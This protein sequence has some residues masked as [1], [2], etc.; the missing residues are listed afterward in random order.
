MS[1][2]APANSTV[3]IFVDGVEYARVTADAAGNWS[4]TPTADLATGAHTINA[5]DEVQGVASVR[6]NTN[7][8]TVATDTTPPD[9]TIVSGPALVTSS[10]SATFDFSANE[11]PVT[12]ECSLDGGAYAACTD[13]QTFT[14]LANGGHTLSVRARDAAG[15]VDPTPATY[16]WTVDTTAPDTTIVSGPAAVT[17]SNSATFDFSSNESPVTYQCSLD[18]AAFVACTDPVTF[19]GLADGNHT[20]AVRA[21]DAAGNVDP[22]P[23]THAWTVDTSPP[24]TVIVSGP[25]AVTSATTATFD[26]SSPDSPVT[27]ECSLDSGAY[28]ACT[29]PVTFTGLA[30]GNHTLSV[31]ARDAAGNVDPTPATYAWRV[32]TTAPDTTIVSGP[33]SVTNSTSAT[34]DFSSNESPVTYQC[35][36]DSGAFV[37]CTDPQTFTGLAQGN[38][39][40]AVRA[41]DA[42]GNVDPTP[43]TYSWTIDTTPPDTA[44]V[45]GPSAVTSSTSA[46]FDFSSPDSPVTYECSLDGA[47]YAA[48]TDPVTFTGLA[49]GNHTLSVRARDA[50]GNVDPTP[51]TH[52]WRVDT[53]VP[54]TVI[55]SG[56]SG[57]TASTSATFDFSS[58]ESPVTYECSLDGAAFAA[59]TDPVTFTGLAQGNHTLSVRAR[60]A[61]GNVDPTPATRSWTVDTV[62][63][64]TSFTSTPPLTTN[65]SV[66]NFDFNSNESP[67]TYEC[68]LDG[69]A[70]FTPCADPQ[71]FTGLANGSHTLEVRA[72]DS[73]GNVDPTPAT[74]TWTVD[75]SPPDTTIVSGPTGSTTSTSA[76]FDFS[77]NESPVTYQCS[78]D[79]AAF[80]ACTDPVTFTGL[81][82]GSH[83][84]SVRAVDAAGNV[85]PTPATRT[86][87]VDRTAPDTTIVSGPATVT[88]ATTATFDFTSNESPVT[89]ECSLDG[90]AFTACTDPV[91]F[92]GLADGGH[93][94]SVRARDA[95]GNVDP[96]P[97]TYA[98]TVDRTAPDTTIVSGPPALTSSTS[99]TFD[100]SSNESPV[101]YQCSLD[102][103]AFAACTD[104][105][106]FS[107]LA[108]G[109]HT[110][111]VR[112]VD[113]AGNVDPTPATHAWTVDRTAPD[114][115]IVSGPALVTNATTATFDFS[116]N[117]SPVTYQCSLDGGAF[118]ACTDPVTFT[119]LAE[120][121]HTLAVR[122]VD[123]A[124]NVDPTPATYSWTV[125][126]TAPTRPVVTAPADGSVVPTQQP[127]FTGTADPGTLVTVIV[128]GVTLG[129]VTANAS[130]NWSFP[131]PVALAQGPHSVVATSTDAAGNVSQPSNTNAFI[132]DTVRP[133]AP[134]IERPADGATVATRRPTY[135]G[136][137]E[138]NAQVTVTVDGRVVGT[139]TAD[140]DGHWS[141]VETTD[142]TDGSHTVDATATDAAGNISEATSHDFLVDTS[143]PDTLIVSGP[144]S[145]TNATSATFDFDQVNGGVRYECSL[146]GAAFTACTDPVTF[147]GLAEGNHTLAVRAVNALGTADASP[148][149]HAWT[150][151]L[152]APTLPT[153]DSPSNGATV[154][155]ATPTITGT[156]EPG[157]SIY[158]DLDGATYGPIPVN[159]Q[160][161]W[162]FTV[163]VP[164]AEGP[165]TV[166]ATSVDAAG[167]TAG[168]VTSTFIVDLLGPDTLIVSGPP[169]LTNTTS[170]TFD[171]DQTGGGVSYQCSLD[172]ASYVPCTD[173]VTFSGLADGEHVL[174]VRAVDAV[175]NVD[176]SPAEHRWTVDTTAPDTLIDS[177]PAL[178]TNATTATFDFEAS[179]PGSTFECSIDGATF[180][181]CTDPDTFAGFAE[182]EHTLEVRAVDAAGNVDP[183][184]ATYT[185]TVDLTA[186]VV[187]TIVTPPNGAV[188]DSG[189]VTITGTADGATSVTLTLGGTT[190]GPIPVDSSGNWTFT[191]PV[192]LADGPYT[193]SVV[194]VDN[195]GNT[196]GPATSTFTVDTSAPDTFIDSGPAALT[197]ETTANF[198]FSSNES[199]VTY[200]CSLDGAAFTAC[201]A[202]ASF[203]SLADGDH[204]LAVRATDAAGNVDASPATHT[205][206]VDTQAPVVT[207][208]TPA[209]GAVLTNPQVTYSGTTE[210]GASVTVVVDGVN[211]GTVTADSSGNWTL[212][213]GTELGEGPHSV[214]VTATDPAGNTSQPV[215]HPF[216][217]DALPPDTTFT[218]TPP[219]L[220]NS[221][222][223]TFEF[224]SDESPVTYECSLDGAAFTACTTPLTLSGL[225]EG[226]HTLSVRARDTDGNVDPTPA[227]YTWTVDTT[228]PDTSIVSGPVLVDAPTT[229][230]FDFDTVGGVSYQCSLDGAAFAACTDPNTFTGLTSGNHTLAVRAVDAA[231]NVDPTP[232]TYAWSVAADTDG[233]GLT[234]AEE[235]VLGTDPNNPDTD[236]DGLPDGIEVNVGHTDPL[237]DDSDDDGI[238]DGTEDA[239]HDGIVDANETDPNNADTD[240]DGLTDGL[241]LGLTQPEGSDTDLSHFTPD[242]DPSTTTNPLNPDTDG[243]SVRDGVEDANH[244]GRVDSGETDPNVAA[245]DTDSDRDG[246]DDRTEIELGLDPH[247][248]DTDDDGVPDGLDGITDTDGDGII[249]ALDPD[250]D[251]DGIYDGTER[252]VTLETAP[253]GTNTSSPNF[254]PDADPSTTTD[255]KKAD[256]DGDGLKDGEEDADH[257]GRV[258][259]TETDPNKADTD[260]DGLGDGVE[261][262]GANPTN[263]LNPDSDEDGLKDGVED[264][265]HNGRLDNGET[266]PNNRDTD[267]G[268]ASDGDEVNGGGNPLDGNDDFIVVGRGCSTGGAGTFAPLA[269]LLLALPMLGRLR[270][271]GRKSARALVAGAAGGV[272][273]TVALVAPSAEA[274]VTAPV[275]SQ[276]IDVQ[277]YKPGTGA[278]DI[279]GVYSPRVQS[280]LNWNVGLSLNYADKPLNFLDPRQDKFIT[281]LVRRQVGLDLMGA[282]GLF[283]RFE[284]GVLLPVT[285]Q[286]SEPAANVDPS[287][288]QG[289]GSGGIGDLR[290][291]PKA[292]LVDGEDFGL[293]LVVPVVLPTGGASDF[294]GGSGVAVQPRLVA[295][296]GQRLRLAANLGVDLRKQQ[297]LRNLVTG[298]AL[299]FGL[300]AELPFTMGNL[301]LAAEATLVGALG[302]KEQ[303]TEERPLELL[304]ALKYRSLGGLSA[305]V[306]AGPGLTRG[307]G[308]PGF[309]VLAGLSY[310]PPPSREPEH[311]APPAPVDTDGD[312]LMDPQDRCPTEPEDKDGFQDEDGCPDPDNDQDGIL[313]GADKCINEPE[314]KNGYE[315][316]DGCPDVVPAPVDTDGDGLLDPNDACPKQ[317]EDKDGF[318][319]A[320]GCPDPDNDKDGIPDVADKCPNEPEVINGVQDDDGC[321]DKGKT[322]VLVDGERILILEKVYFATNKDVILARSF[323]LL[324]Q[325]AAVLRANPQVE[326]LRIEGHTDNQGNDASNLDLSKRRAANV[327]KF[328]VN[329]GIA[330]ER[331]ESQGYGETKPVDTNKTAAGRENNRRVEFTI[332]R[333]GKVEVE[334]DA[335]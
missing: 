262:K 264:A 100:F 138:P 216:T 112:A 62:A 162:T 239:D 6:S 233:D 332:L 294:L 230:I 50:A 297:Q 89:Y 249:D 282:V 29:D 44:I 275:A 54:D 32:D 172:G 210:P 118:A 257:N 121:G 212:P 49:E 279:L 191:P 116:S 242:A 293:A 213:V 246:I 83:T 78:L 253:V 231:G 163:P 335:Q 92:S 25:A 155:T 2:T 259:A 85:D 207:L 301:P 218:A 173:P 9:T 323:P 328:L 161:D 64:D 290:L 114:T 327:R 318:Q 291:V 200:E 148:A 77:S 311:V 192:T 266:D 4:Y 220:T 176:P 312:G 307:Y 123:A 202:Q 167:N 1:G 113:A 330:A 178:V 298:N 280:H 181:P 313:D 241:E 315:D 135:E 251:N 283:D 196:S 38:H 15:N 46:T 35:S 124:G 111:S 110:L 147:T 56:P 58:P 169:A 31:R 133:D 183:T 203:S 97:A 154:G 254:R 34:F 10:T 225:S 177:G 232:A 164:L 325:V 272:A 19:T 67:V 48:C 72:V 139:V 228:P 271:A 28:A 235:V 211:V 53:T 150:V 195:V 12:Y 288:A 27:Y 122:A 310:S 21:V 237:D 186:P 68:R 33:A 224:T 193:I 276:A 296:Y 319:D 151:D 273:L 234:D 41:V 182:G 63:P 245:D 17:N 126:R 226:N 285:L 166:T 70:L 165:Y 317:A 189:V 316:A 18:G 137:S 320:D 131:S 76:T 43:A 194:A 215:T 269:L 106:T 168:P 40:L 252:G 287:F 158:L 80:T 205:W 329:E 238:M 309:R 105:V 219:A 146:D 142:L 90:A 206:T 39:T 141:I 268:G 308:T 82:D 289:V 221:T 326:L 11:S 209:S 170:A 300:G 286:D 95:A 217:V 14:G 125:D 243:G 188:L 156:G 152:T 180:V 8:F 277:Q 22:T 117:E 61:A 129:T 30:Q 93:T 278:W 184:P 185:W 57:V 109:N 37:A 303:D 145:R 160:G 198:T 223:A 149:T 101:T 74:Y 171:F 36:L 197:R 265:N 331:L 236:G 267:Q 84:L 187:P 94:L 227:T 333:V 281:S 248:A 229:A 240:G 208:T 103:A 45:S 55:V 119:G 26:F 305:H 59:C 47:A 98:W 16:A 51:A 179:E 302:F 157:S 334:R 69:A 128:D 322:K 132:V 81:A 120:G 306:G 201:P 65:S 5:Y 175:G 104:P 247:D 23:A 60:D 140:G 274:Q 214:T 130:G 292:R 79:G 314:T 263:P 159:A 190:Y 270:R 255:P 250:S 86:W 174:L 304:A 107:G 20:L 96:T 42:A 99:A 134:V 295:E 52:S 299:A 75:T 13:P 24:D 71:T 136:T 108:D 284:L 261:V 87:T 258:D 88:N 102:G 143:G 7:T 324:K 222:S 256:T 153:I 3:V 321:P 127:T 91:T 199:P 204:T 144:P 115:T 66:A 244:N 260:G 73:A